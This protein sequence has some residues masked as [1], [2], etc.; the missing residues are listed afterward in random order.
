[1]EYE[2]CYVFTPEDTRPA[3]R[4]KVELS[5]LQKSWPVREKA[6][7]TAWSAQQARIDAKVNTIN[8]TTVTDIAQFLDEAVRIPATDRIPAGLILAGPNSALRASIAAQ[9][10]KQTGERTRRVLATISSN[11]GSNLKG[12]VR[13]I[14]QKATSSPEGEDD[15]DGEEVGGS[16][17]KG[18]KLLKYDLQILCDFVQERRIQQVVIAIEDTEAFD[19]DLLSELIELLSCWQGRI[20]FA[21]LFNVATSVEFLQQRLSKSAVRCLQGRLFDAELSADEVEQVF[22]AIA[23]TEVRLWLGAGL[24][25]MMLERQSDYI[26]SIDSLA[27]AAKYAYMSCFFANALSV[28]LD[29]KVEFESV[30]KD[31]FEALRNLDSFR[32]EATRRLEAGEA[33]LVRDLL[34]RDQAL[35]TFTQQA[36]KRGRTA[37]AEMVAA[38]EVIRTVQQY[39]PNTPVTTKSKL[40]VQAMSG[41]LSNSAQLR[42]LFLSLRKAHSN[43]ARQILE[44]LD[45][46]SRNLPPQDKYS[47]YCI[48]ADLEDLVQGMANLR[49]PLRSE[50][51]VQNSTM[52]TTVVA[53]KV[54]LSKQKSVL[55]EQDSAY[56]I[57]IRKFSK[58]L[59]EFLAD[60]LV[61]PK[62]LPFHEIFVYDLKSPYREVFTPRPRHAIERALASP[63]DYLDCECCAPGQGDGEEATLAASQPATAVLYQLY[64]ES[65]LLINASDLWQAF[66]AVVGDK[67]EDEQKTM[68]LFQRALSEL[69][70]LGF[71]KATRKRVDHVAKVAWKGL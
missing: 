66:Q 55:S 46:D 20:P 51:D 59:Q 27:Q 57:I 37:L 11:A 67:L 26:Q 13:T 39:L 4:R 17:R 48:R 53:Q 47:F 18:A 32:N 9:V 38:T 6:Y 43:I 56:T 54:E 44:A 60:K 28:F 68:A 45:D 40:Y 7:Q 63:H 19:S 34:D 25:A 22:E 1:M 62:D 65:G 23:S 33:K 30:P 12:L 58:L 41:K 8:A 15:D 5:G 14:I 10:A 3:K 24:T 35:F 16:T 50:D 69:R 2:K 49:I 31:H 61:N 21:C 42:S 71:V 29:P 64:L 70:H 36:V 52:R